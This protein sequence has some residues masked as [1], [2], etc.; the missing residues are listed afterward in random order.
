MPDS[1]TLSK[2]YNFVEMK[3]FSTT[4]FA[5]AILFSSCSKSIILQ[6]TQENS[7]QIPSSESKGTVLMFITPDCP[8]S[9]AY[10]F[11]FKELANDFP[12]YA[13]YAVLPGEHYSK[14]ELR[15][16][17]DSFHFNIPILLDKKYELTHNLKAT[18][19]PEFFLLDNSGNIKYQGAFDN[20]AITL[21]RKR[22]KPNRFWLKN[23]VR[24]FSKDSTIVI[25]KTEAVGCVIE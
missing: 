16:F 20:W 3:L 6:D 21:A 7:H 1:R 2:Y 10:T 14:N 8:L 11:N 25:S 19:T 5:I 13:Y 15:H 9:H 24:Q 4:L 17:A 22:I 18:I 12:N 23:A